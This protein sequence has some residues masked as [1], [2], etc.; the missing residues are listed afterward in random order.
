VITYSGLGLM[1]RFGN[2]LFQIASTIGIARRNGHDFCFP[3]WEHQS[4]FSNKL[5][6]GYAFGTEIKEKN[7]HYDE[8]I[9]PKEGSFSLS[10]YFQSWRYFEYCKEEILRYFSFPKR[11]IDNV[12]VHIRRGDYVGREH[13]H[14]LIPP[15]Y[16]N[17]AMDQ[18]P[19]RNFIVFSDDIK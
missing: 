11:I 14:G 7:F 3:K 1:G 13:F 18:F 8:Y 16:Y 6:E 4:H 15:S 17:L 5:P 12:A 2:Q 9:L 19:G 10:G